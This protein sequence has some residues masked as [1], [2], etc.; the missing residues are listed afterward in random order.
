M[1]KDEG[2]FRNLVLI[3]LLME[4]NKENEINLARHELEFYFSRLPNSKKIKMP[5]LLNTKDEAP[6]K[7]F[8]I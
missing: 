2:D 3:D 6:K 7:V 4:F 1:Q 5:L 8:T